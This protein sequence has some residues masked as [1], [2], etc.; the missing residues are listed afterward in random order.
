MSKMLCHGSLLKCS[1]GVAPGLLNI[2]PQNQVMISQLP[3]GTI[4]D[5]KPLVNISTF[6]MCNSMMNPMVA[7]ATAAAM[8]ALTPM[9]CAPATTAP[10]TPGAPQVMIKGIPVITQQS[11]CMCN[12]G[13]I[14]EATMPMQMT[15]DAK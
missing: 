3:A 4:M 2:L 11:K 1:F 7:T 10:W 9:P 8:G 12:W 5:N 6:G 15:V 14:I 13:G